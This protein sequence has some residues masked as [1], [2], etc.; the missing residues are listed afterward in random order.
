MFSNS[1]ATVRHCNLNNSSFGVNFTGGSS[2]NVLFCDM[3]TISFAGVKVGE[4]SAVTLLR[5]LRMTTTS[6]GVYGTVGGACQRFRESYVL[7]AIGGILID[8]MG[9]LITGGYLEIESSTSHGMQV[10][11]NAL[12]Y[13]VQGANSVVNNSNGW[14]FLASSGGLGVSASALNYSGNASGDRSP[15]TAPDAGTT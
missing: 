8:S 15:A 3:K 1:A 9:I 10:R 11:E 4:N 6:Y 5:G 2:G 7:G 12:L 13:I 14:G